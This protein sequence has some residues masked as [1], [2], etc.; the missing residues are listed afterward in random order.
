MLHAS[1]TGIERKRNK[2]MSGERITVD[3]L[4]PMSYGGI[5]A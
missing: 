1:K 5:V 4:F 3:D 2:R